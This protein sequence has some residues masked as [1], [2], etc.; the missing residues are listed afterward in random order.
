MILEQPQ[1][2][3]SKMRKV[4]ELRWQRDVIERWLDCSGISEESHAQLQEMLAEVNSA[5]QAVAGS[6]FISEGRVNMKQVR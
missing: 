3:E 6:F 4:I 5:L 2:G 1:Y